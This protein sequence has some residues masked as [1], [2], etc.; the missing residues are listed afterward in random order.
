MEKDLPGG[1]FKK[2]IGKLIAGGLDKSPFPE[3]GVKE[4]KRQLKKTLRAHGIEESEKKKGDAEQVT[5]VRLIQG[6]LKAFD[7]PDHYFC[8]WW[9]RGVWLGSPDRPL[10]RA[11]VLYDRKV[12]WPIKE[13]GGHLHGS[14]APTTPP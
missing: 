12:R 8:E 1:A 14:G 2:T 4:V 11:R 10:P 6:L 3:A 13:D 5:D 7:D 9:A